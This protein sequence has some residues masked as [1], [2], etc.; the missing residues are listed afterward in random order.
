MYTLGDMAHPHK[1][2]LRRKIPFGEIHRLYGRV[3]LKWI[4]LIV[5]LCGLGS[6]DTALL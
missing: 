4:I 6:T 1:G 5:G 2:K 3:V